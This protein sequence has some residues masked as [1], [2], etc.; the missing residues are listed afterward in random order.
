VR[1]AQA[2]IAA[3]SDVRT[4]S[5]PETGHALMAERPDAVLDALR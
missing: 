2:L 1:N 3:L 5:L 4:V